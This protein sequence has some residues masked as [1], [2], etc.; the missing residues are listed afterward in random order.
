M[1]DLAQAMAEAHDVP[2]RVDSGFVKLTWE[3]LKVILSELEE[4][5]SQDVQDW[6]REPE[7]FTFL[8]ESYLNFIG[9]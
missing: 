3:S 8:K 5:F 9:E 4:A 1:Q 7:S 6:M 2:L